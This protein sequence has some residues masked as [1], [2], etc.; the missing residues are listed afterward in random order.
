M[1]DESLAAAERLAERG[2]SVGQS[3]RGRSFPST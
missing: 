3:I 1:V 2:I